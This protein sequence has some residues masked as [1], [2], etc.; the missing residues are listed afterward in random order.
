MKCL[1]IGCERS[2]THGGTH[3]SIACALD[4]QILSNMIVVDDP[5]LSEE[6]IQSN[7]EWWDAS[8]RASKQIPSKAIIIMSR[9]NNKK[10]REMKLT[11]EELEALRKKAAEVL[12]C[13]NPLCP[14]YGLEGEPF[15]AQPT[16]NIIIQEQYRQK[17]R[18]P[19]KGTDYETAEP[20]LG[21]IRIMCETCKL[22]TEYCNNMKG[23]ALHSFGEFIKTQ[24]GDVTWLGVDE[25]LE[26]FIEL[27]YGVMSISP[28][29]YAT[30]RTRPNA[31]GM[32]FKEVS[33][34]LDFQRET[35]TSFP[36]G[37]LD[38]LAG[39][40]HRRRE[41]LISLAAA[42]MLALEKESAEAWDPEE[43]K[44]SERSIEGIKAFLKAE[45]KARPLRQKEN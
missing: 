13:G 35:Q 39:T 41:S 27:R 24:I 19:T 31:A 36:L 14:D 5:H 17:L 38:Q 7:L 25:M 6:T 22:P 10:E 26:D 33:R 37:L 15:A 32:A 44:C 21:F 11:E 29:I 4:S 40:G 1:G 23:S 45:K 20:G 9:C 43:D 18:T 28:S 8:V 16:G 12:K 34:E 30:T 42:C 3:C 2:F